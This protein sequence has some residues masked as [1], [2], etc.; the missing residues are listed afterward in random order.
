MPA[1]DKEKKLQVEIQKAVKDYVDELIS[2]RSGPGK[3]MAVSSNQ[4]MTATRAAGQKGRLHSDI[5]TEHAFPISKI[6]YYFFVCL[7]VSRQIYYFTDA[8]NNNYP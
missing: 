3:G 8:K 5:S 2:E 6:N 1:K 7:W 4:L